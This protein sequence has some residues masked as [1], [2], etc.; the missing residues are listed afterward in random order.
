MSATVCKF[1]YDCHRQDCYYVHPTGRFID[2]DVYNM[3]MPVQQHQQQQYIPQQQQFMQSTQQSSSGSGSS[4]QP[5]VC[6][7]NRRCQRTNCY[8]LHPNGR[9]MDFHNDNELDEVL[10]HIDSHNG[11]NKQQQS[12]DD[13]VC[14]CCHGNPDNCNNEQ[15][16]QR[17]YCGCQFGQTND[18]SDSNI[19]EQHLAELEGWR[20]EWFSASREC[21]CCH[22]YVYRCE[23]INEDCEDAYC[24]C[25][26]KNDIPKPQV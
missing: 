15:C 8:F 3:N 6:K 2:S 10:N 17:G 4:K 7:F 23:H 18:S 19:I 24:Y 9:A 16:K 20:D 22:G 1:G 25:G 26:S 14:P 5:Q 11:N 21:D 13:D 12:T